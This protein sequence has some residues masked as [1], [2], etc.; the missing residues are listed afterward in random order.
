MSQGHS[1]RRAVAEGGAVVN[2][3]R[4]ELGKAWILWLLAYLMPIAFLVA[5]IIKPEGVEHVIEW[6][7][8]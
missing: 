7:R 6:L 3:M 2:T 1:I 8:R 4:R 5:C